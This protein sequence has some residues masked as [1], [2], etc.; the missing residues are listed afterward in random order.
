MI[1][2]KTGFNQI[3]KKIETALNK[4]LKVEKVKVGRMEGKHRVAAEWFNWELKEN[5]KLRGKLSRR[6]RIARKKNEA[7]E[8]IN[9]Y[10]L[11]YKNQQTTTAKIIG[12]KKGNR[13]KEKI[14]DAK[15]N[16]KTLWKVVNAL[17]GK[18]KIRKKRFFYIEKMEQNTN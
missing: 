10:E 18:T 5:I 15:I 4:T 9:R 14:K 2:K 1:G 17:L 11:E 3:M 16:G 13:G 6:W 12:E 7:Q 8:T